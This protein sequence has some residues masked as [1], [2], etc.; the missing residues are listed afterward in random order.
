MHRGRKNTVRRWARNLITG[1][2]LLAWLL[3]SP[4]VSR[5]NRYAGEFLQVAVGAR[6][7]GMGGAYCSLA[8]EGFAPYW[9]PAGIGRMGHGALSVQHAT[10]FD[11][12]QHEYINLTLP[13]PNEASLGFTWIR[14]GVDAIPVFPEPGRSSEGELQPIEEWMVTPMEFFND[15]EDAFLLTFA[16]LNRIDLDLGWQYFVVPLTLPLGLNLKYIHQSLGDATATGMGIDMGTQLGFGLDQ[17]LDYEPLGDFAAGL[18]LQN[19]GKTALN[20]D[21]ET[22]HRDNIPFNM[23]FGFSYTQPLASESIRAVLAYDRDTA[24]DGQ[25]HFGLEVAYRDLLALRLGAEEKELTMGAGLHIWL[26]TLDYAFV[27]YDLGNIHRIS[28]AVNF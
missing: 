17:F 13:L 6:A 20:W 27:S 4:Q 12:A 7:L 26:L 24:Y 15:A 18:N 1:T 25:N 19:I 5:A 28:G 8:Q 23:K 2:A 10:L 16:K 9:N 3:G 14:L 11:L 21:T 22:K